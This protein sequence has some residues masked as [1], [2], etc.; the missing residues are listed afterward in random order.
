MSVA[1]CDVFNTLNVPD[2]NTAVELTFLNDLSNPAEL[3]W[4]DH[5]GQDHAVSNSGTVVF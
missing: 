4:V 3:F 2:S 1:L 5:Q